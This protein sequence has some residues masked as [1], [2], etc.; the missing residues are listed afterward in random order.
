MKELN[1]QYGEL[2]ESK[3]RLYGEYRKER[4]RMRELQTVQRVVEVLMEKDDRKIEKRIR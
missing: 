1:R 2:L 4:E 3:R